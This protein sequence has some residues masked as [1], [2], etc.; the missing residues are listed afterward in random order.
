MNHSARGHIRVSASQGDVTADCCP[1]SQVQIGAQRGNIARDSASRVELHLPKQ[2]RNIALHIPMDV[3][4]AKHTGDVPRSLPFGHRDI[5]PHSN[6]F[7]PGSREGG[8]GCN[9]KGNGKKHSAHRNLVELVCGSL[10]LDL[11][12]QLDHD[13]L[14]I[15]HPRLIFVLPRRRAAWSNRLRLEC[16]VGLVYG[17]R[18]LR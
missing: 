11:D 17:D 10:E 13:R 3:N 2:N 5:A 12:L 6:V 1:W 8:K 16:L 14:A 4:I 18:R 15:L 9:N 7:A